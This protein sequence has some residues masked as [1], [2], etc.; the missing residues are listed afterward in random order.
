MP[1]ML[2]VLIASHFVFIQEASSQAMVAFFEKFDEQGSRIELE[3]GGRFFH[4]AIWNG[5]AWV[6]AHP[7]Y[8][9]IE[10]SEKVAS[11]GELAVILRHDSY[12]SDHLNKLK[13][14]LNRPYDHQFDWSRSDCFYCSELV[15]KALGVEPHLEMGFRASHWQESLVNL[16]RGEL[17]L[18]PD[19][20][21]EPLI[22]QGFYEI[23][24]CQWTHLF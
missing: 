15:A 21:I 20:L 4:V 11:I 16:P 13:R 2:I 6:H 1:W 3:P 18:S 7:S 5:T 22:E 23:P 24:R 14:W 12:S 9:V 19:D 8:G 10:S 17:G